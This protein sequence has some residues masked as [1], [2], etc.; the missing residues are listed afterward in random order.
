DYLKGDPVDGLSILISD[1]SG[2]LRDTGGALKQ[3][4]DLLRGS[5]H[6]LVHNADVITDLDLNSLI[7][8]HINSNALATLAVRKR[9]SSRYLLVDGDEHL[10]GWHNTTTGEYLWVRGSVAPHHRMAFSGVYILSERVLDMLP[11]REKF[12]IIPFLLDMAASH[13]VMTHAHD[14]GIWTDL[15]RPADLQSMDRWLSGVEGKHWTDKYLAGW[16]PSLPV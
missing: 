5:G 12:G 8:S 9:D 15:G 4:A 3:A 2:N 13:K 6:I 16:S 10:T 1:E 14:Y 7:E 11:E